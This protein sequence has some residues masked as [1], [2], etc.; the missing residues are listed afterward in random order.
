[1][2]SSGLL[3]HVA[4]VRTDVSEERS[5]SIIRVTRIGEPGTLAVTSN[6]YLEL[7]LYKYCWRQPWGSLNSHRKVSILLDIAP[8]TPCVLTFRRN[9]NHY[10]PGL[11]KDQSPAA[12]L[13]HARLIFRPWRWSSCSSETSVHMRGIGRYIR[14]DGNIHNYAVRTSNPT[15]GL[16]FEVLLTPWPL[17]RERTIPT[18]RPPLVDEI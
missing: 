18:E 2:P 5:A 1:M 9:V 15:K 10:I 7:V 14:Q 6:R 16:G 3:A 12:R 17:V 13:F 11:N 4:L 8:C